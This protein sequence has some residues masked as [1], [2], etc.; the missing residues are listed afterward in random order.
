MK[1]TFYRS[2]TNTRI[3]GVCGGI[4]EGFE[5]DANIIRLIWVVITILSIPIG[6]ILYL[7]CVF[8]FPKN[9]E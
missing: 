8:I 5:I 3:C 4:G 7:A 1:K 9:P 6:L 2:N